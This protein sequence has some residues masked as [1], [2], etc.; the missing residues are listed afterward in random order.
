MFSKEL[1]SI[2]WLRGIGRHLRPGGPHRVRV[3]DPVI[4]L[5]PHPTPQPK[6]T[7]L[8]TTDS[9]AWL[10]TH[11]RIARISL[12]VQLALIPVQCTKKTF[13]SFFFCTLFS[14][15]FC[16]VLF[17]TSCYILSCSLLSL[18]IPL[19]NLILL[20]LRLFNDPYRLIV[21]DQLHVWRLFS[22]HILPSSSVFR[23]VCSVD[24]IF[25]NLVNICS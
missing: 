7:T 19:V 4:W 6:T 2:L 12:I 8:Q 11:R 20:L 16:C 18:P 10:T 1:P 24:L 5:S 3:E 23:Y 21:I 17:T 13:S 22:L 25:T 15:A 14:L 9:Q